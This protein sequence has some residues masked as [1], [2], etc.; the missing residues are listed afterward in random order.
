MKGRYFNSLLTK[1]F[2]GILEKRCACNLDGLQQ[3]PVNESGKMRVPKLTGI[4]DEDNLA[5]YSLSLFIFYPSLALATGSCDIY[6]FSGDF[7]FS[8]RSCA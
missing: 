5:R 8:R 4:D 2:L 6:F 7:F 1:I 3:D